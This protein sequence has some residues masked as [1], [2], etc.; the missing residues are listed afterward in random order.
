MHTGHLYRFQVCKIAKITIYNYTNI[1]KH[2]I[3][4]KL[5]WDKRG[6]G[7]WAV[8]I[9]KSWKLRIY[10]ELDR[11]TTRVSTTLIR[12]IK[13]TDIRRWTNHLKQEAWSL[14]HWTSTICIKKHTHH[15]F[16]SSLESPNSISN[17]SNVSPHI[18]I[19]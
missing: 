6:V 2:T 8:I 13:C 4:N 15:T 12:G 3:I 9:N 17:Q 14:E 19:H 11:M 16:K 5:R 18:H 7:A 10:Q 1:K